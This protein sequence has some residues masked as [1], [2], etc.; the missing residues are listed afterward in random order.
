MARDSVQHSA[1]VELAKK[2]GLFDIKD[3]EQTLPK[4]EC[5]PTSYARRRSKYG[6]DFSKE[7]RQKDL[8]EDIPPEEFAECRYA[9]T[10]ES[11][12]STM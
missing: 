7:L 4:E 8:L 11:L 3:L 9:I 5:K 10:I 2:E 6:S 1:F 12:N